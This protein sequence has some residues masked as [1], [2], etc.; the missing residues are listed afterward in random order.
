MMSLVLRSC[1]ELHIETHTRTHTFISKEFWHI[2]LPPYSDRN[3]PQ[4]V[5][6]KLGQYVFSVGVGPILETRWEVRESTE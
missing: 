1:T 2:T 3:T 5:A 6:Y 4:S